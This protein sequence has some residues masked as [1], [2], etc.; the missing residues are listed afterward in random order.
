MN[1]HARY[2]VIVTLCLAPMLG[3]SS[4]PSSTADSGP[5]PSP[6]TRNV[7]GDTQNGIGSAGA[8]K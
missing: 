6:N 7:A 1:L 8:L 5:R 4:F 3:C 2:L